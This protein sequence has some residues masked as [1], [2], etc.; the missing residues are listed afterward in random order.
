[1]FYGQ[2]KKGANNL[3]LVVKKSGNCHFLGKTFSFHVPGELLVADK[4]G[5]KDLSNKLVPLI[6]AMCGA[7]KAVPVPAL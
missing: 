5:I 7:K 6:R 3:F 4:T 1:M 2:Q